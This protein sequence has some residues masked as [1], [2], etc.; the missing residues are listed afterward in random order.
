[1][2]ARPAVADASTNKGREVALKMDQR[3]RGFGDFQASVEMVLLNRSGQQR[4]LQMGINV[5]EQQDPI[6]KSLIRFSHPRDIDG[7]AVLT[8]ANRAR[9]DDQW[10][11]LPSMKRSKR[12]SSANRSGA[13]V[14]SDF[15]YE[16]LIRQDVEKYSYRY[17]EQKP[18]GKLTCDVVERVSTNAASGYSRQLL[19]VDT[20][21]YRPMRVEFFDR[22]GK[23]LKT[24]D[25]SDYQVYLKD[26][27]RPGK[28][29]MQN[30]QSGHSTVLTWRDYKFQN[31]FTEADFTVGN[32]AR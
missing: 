10:L 30:H 16:D 23:L 17:M 25:Y 21:F 9:E 14:G 13:F 4:T 11:F 15:S 7:T 27:W 31:G 19:W 24:L 2:P 18:C 5:L 3:D 12:I 29:H 22:G 26:F 8:Y 6:E 1:M 20:Q 32:L 28:M